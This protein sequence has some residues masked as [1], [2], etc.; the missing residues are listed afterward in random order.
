TVE[1]NSGN[2]AQCSYTV[3]VEDNEDPTITCIAPPTR[4]T[5]PGECYYTVVGT[6]FDPVD[7]DDNCGY[8]LTNDYNGLSTLDGEQIVDGTTIVWTVED[9]SGNTA[10]CN[11]SVTIIDNEDP[12]ISCPNDTSV[13]QDGSCTAVV[14]NLS[15]SVSDNCGVII[16]TWTMTGATTNSSAT[17]GINDVSGETFEIGVTTVEYYIEDASGNSATCSFTVEIYDEVDGGL[18]DA[19]QNICYNSIPNPF[20]NEASASVCGGF[21]YQWQMKTGSAPWED[22]SG[23]TNETYTETNPLT[24]TTYYNRK[25]ISDL[26]FGTAYSDTISITITPAPTVYAGEDT[27]LCYGTPYYIQDAD[28]TNS[29]GIDWSTEGDGDFDDNSIID[30][31]YTPGPEDL[32]NG[33]V[34][35]VIT[36]FG[37]TP[38][39]DVS[40]TVRINYLPEL[41]ASIGKPTPFLIDSTISGTPTHIEIY[42]KISDHDYVANLGVYLISPLDSIVELKPY[43]AGFPQGAWP[44][45]A[46]YKFYNDPLDTSTTALGVIDECIA[47]SGTYEFSGDWKKK[48]HGQDPA[49][50]AWRIRI[51]DSRNWGDPGIIEEAVIKF[52]DINYSGVF[53]NVLYAD[54]L[55]N[56]NIN[57][58]GGT[59]SYT[60]TDYA[61]PITGLT[62]SC[63]GICDATAVGTATGGQPPYVSY[64]WSDVPDFSNIIATTDTVDL[65]AGTFYLRITD[66]HGCVAI[67]SVTVGE[68]PEIIIDSDTVVHNICYGDSIG[69]I[70]LEFS[71]G[72]GAL[73]YTIDGIDWYNS[74]DT[75]ENLAAGDY[76]A[77]IM[78]ATG[79]TKDTMITINQPTPIDI[80][81]NYTGIS[82]Y[83]SADGEIEITATGGTPGV[84]NPYEY[85]IDSAQSWQ[86]SNIFGG[87]ASDTFYV[88]V[89]DSLGCIQFGDTITINEPDTIVIDSIIT[90]PYSC[91]GEGDDGEIIV[92]ASGGV[93]E[94]KYSITGEQPFE[95]DS[96]FTGLIG[97]TYSV[98]IEDDCGVDTFEN[99]AVITGPDPI[100][101]DSIN[102]NDVNTCYGDSAG[103]IELFVSGGTGNFEYYINGVVNDPPESNIFTDLP[104]QDYTIYALDDKGCSSPDS[105]VT[106]NQPIELEISGLDVI[107]ASVC[108]QDMTGSIT[109]HAIGGTGDYEFNVDGESFQS[110]STFTGLDVGNHTL[111]V[112]DENGCETSVDTAINV[113]EPLTVSFDVSSISC[114]G[115]A[116]GSISVT[117]HDG[118]PGYN[119]QWNT[120]DSTSTINNLSQGWYR[121]TVTDSNI[122][123]SC[124]VIDSVEIVEP[125][126]LEIAATV[127]DIFCV[128]SKSL[129]L[130][131]SNG[132]INI[133]ASGGT[134][135][136]TYD[137][138]GPSGFT[139]GSYYIRDLEEGTYYLTVTDANGCDTTYNTS[140]SKDS[141][142]DIDFAIE[143]EDSSICWNEELIFN[144]TSNGADTIFI[145]K[146]QQNN[147]GNWIA[148][149]WYVEITDDEFSFTDDELAGNAR[150][151]LEARNEYCYEDI[152]DISVDYFA[153]RELAIAENDDPINDTIIIK[154][155]NGR[156]YAEAGV[157]NPNGLIVNWI[158]ADGVATPDSLNTWISPS[159]SM[160]YSVEIITQEGGCTDADSIYISYVPD[161]ITYDGFSPN[162][163]GINDFWYIENIDAFENNIVT[164]YNRWGVKVYEQKGYSNNDSNRRWDG[165]GKN[166]KPLGS[167]TYY[168]VII[169]NEE[170]FS[171]LTGAITIMR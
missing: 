32:L 73:Q 135:S 81:T 14:N 144:S 70:A 126:P 155:D 35:L 17:T 165:T 160:W 102:V 146:Y 13:I 22:I 80:T 167:G 136:Y 54:S 105:T 30:P 34:D 131:N 36:S 103:T 50:G 53:E 86:S 164:V 12:I 72:T 40:D 107:D 25:A 60:I 163:D 68:P 42:V 49:N 57:G 162:G 39:N 5:D 125:D 58:Y 156:W 134:P 109:I 132:K 117:P 77:T 84:I 26:G 3:T 11:Y 113:I 122:P 159:E 82:C 44:S 99:V 158:P 120:G 28:S 15:P 45:D 137:W 128:N 63:Y 108:N 97:G 21:T 91:F 48:L 161:I 75:I 119:Y 138:T 67:D 56:L 116:D 114:N 170:G 4:N 27:T 43:C 1:D 96:H 69:K 31:I 78:D 33:Y 89:Q 118:T 147:D 104:A 66:S 64:E 38:C 29:F 90:V 121:V 129:D 79:C 83:G 59:G 110:D 157:N 127:K 166:G 85:S 152:S 139:S 95:A 115:D 100:V 87:L 123:E 20:T 111:I 94:L 9:N 61:L 55:V 106:I 46:V 130:E 19:D 145:Q 47:S 23:A 168:Y 151:D 143:L 149:D 7:V 98:Y 140:I 51:V 150:Y 148:S 171:P 41:L 71:G 74:G 6:E 169:L 76:L 62:T 52:S 101:I 24:E 133:S 88:A 65:C 10:Q 154:G 92:Y 112:R 2:T 93:G 8:T 141:D 18:I 124:E 153:D 37:N 16:Q 142:Y